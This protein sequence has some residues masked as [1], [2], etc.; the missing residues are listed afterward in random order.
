VR[1]LKIDYSKAQIIGH[2][3]L[4][5]DVNRNGE[6]ESMEDEGVSAL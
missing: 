1:V 5:P 6:V 4:S 3:D 2:M